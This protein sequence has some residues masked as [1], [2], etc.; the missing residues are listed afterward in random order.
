MTDR[1]FTLVTGLAQCVK[2]KLAEAGIVVCDTFVVT[3]EAVALDHMGVGVAW[4]REATTTITE[5]EG[6][7]STVCAQPWRVA[8]EVGIALCH[9][10]QEEPLSLDQHL[11]MAVAVSDAKSALWKAIACCPEWRPQNKRAM[12]VTRWQPI[13]PSGGVVGGGWLLTADV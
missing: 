1:A 6:G 3:G 7:S 4:V 10:L 12:S 9:P 13:G 11:A 2:D 8:L 5:V